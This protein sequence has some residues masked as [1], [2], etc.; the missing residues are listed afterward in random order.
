MQT[1]TLYNGCKIP[2]IGFGTFPQKEALCISV[3]VAMSCGYRMIDAS[4]NY[5]NERFAGE[6]IRIGGGNAAMTIVTKFSKPLKTASLE[7][8]FAASERRL[9]GKIDV[10]LLHW[11][12]PFL[13]R[14]QWRRMEDL[15]NAGRCKAIGVCNFE[16]KTLRELLRFCH[17]KPAINQFERHPL[18]QQK[19]TAEICRENGVAVMSYPPLARMPPT[20][21]EN[22]T[23]KDIAR[24][25][26]KSVEQVVL[27]WNIEHGDI[28]IPASRSPK[29]IASNFNIFDFS[30]SDEEVI[31]ID[32]LDS[33]HRIR[34]NPSSRFSASDRLRFMGVGGN[35]LLKSLVRRGMGRRLSR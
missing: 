20:L 29:H 13:W 12:Y 18:F 23:L 8:H 14:E 24:R 15:Y 28:P 34:L 9:G 22:A 1:V 2:A 33:G 27:R 21:T 31:R 25:H 17:V 6:G 26:G 7:N 4:D 11:P 16:A 30:L 5:G 10:Y 32:S 19:A 3:P 35:I